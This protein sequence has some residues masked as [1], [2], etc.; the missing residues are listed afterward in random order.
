MSTGNHVR[1]DDLGEVTPFIE[2][3]NTEEILA[4]VKQFLELGEKL[5]KWI[6]GEQDDKLVAQAKQIV[7]FV[8]PIVSQPWFED[9]LKV[10]LSLIAK[11]DPAKFQ[12]ALEKLR[13]IAA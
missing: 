8:E 4:K 9:I 13:E 1:V 12:A 6:P 11:K 5:A 10:V 7:A 2:A 3:T